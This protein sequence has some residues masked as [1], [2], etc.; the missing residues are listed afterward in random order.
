MTAKMMTPSRFPMT[1]KGL[2]VLTL[3]I[4]MIGVHIERG[5][6]EVNPP[7]LTFKE[8]DGRWTNASLN[9]V[10]VAAQAG[11]ATAQCQLGARLVM[12]RGVKTNLA[13]GAEW[14]RKAAEQG[15]AHAQFR[16]GMMYEQGRGVTKSRD[17]AMEWMRKAADQG[18]TLAELNLGWMYANDEG[19]KPG[20]TIT[21]NYPVAAEWYEKAA[22]KGNAQAQFLLAE[23][24]RYRKL[25]ESKRTNCVEW[26]WKAAS[27]GHVKAQAAVGELLDSFPNHALLRSSQTIPMLR[28][29]AGKGN[30]DAQFELAKRYRSGNGVE[31]N[32][33]EAFKWMKLAANN[34]TE[35][36]RV[37]DASYE[38]GSMYEKG[39]GVGMNLSE[40]W[41]SY[42]TAA[43]G[44]YPDALF[45]VGRMYEEGT[46]VPKDLK[47]AAEHYFLAA[48]RGWG[49]FGKEALQ[50]L[51]ALYLA[52]PD[53]SV[54]KS[55]VE[56]QLKQ[57]EHTPRPE[58][59]FQLGEIYNQGKA[60][61]KDDALAVQHYTEAARLGSPEA[62]F[63]IGQ[64]WASGSPGQLDLREAA[65]WYRKAAE[66]GLTEAQFK[67]GVCYAT[68]QGLPID[69]IEAW[70]WLELATLQKHDDAR[71]ER[72]KLEKSMTPEQLSEAKAK[73]ARF[74]PPPLKQ[75][76]KKSN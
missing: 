55:N 25:G 2:V 40:A 29:A 19:T 69:R 22:R 47:Q 20:Q 45:R 41:Q 75:Q 34:G 42:Q 18:Y 48:T 74:T 12:G 38:L 68:G 33:P 11:D 70:H 37:F 52:G 26:Y 9:E 32:L 49:T 54:E 63:R 14:Y 13:E 36:S 7:P 8:I 27:Q 73:V 72:N 28:Q 31:T 39:E 46:G 16:L 17:A 62:Q 61:S 64:M 1:L 65:V 43:G 59:Q 58:V 56:K 76:S 21:G 6:A 10:K 30:L 57:F 24:Y 4:P 67:L 3:A 60:V 44:G 35:S 53:F 51:L 66:Q 5:Q 50:H 15:L 71:K 23:L